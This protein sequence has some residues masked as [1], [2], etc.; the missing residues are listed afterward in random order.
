[1]LAAERFRRLLSDLTLTPDDRADGLRAQR[2]VRASLQAHYYGGPSI[3]DHSRLI[4]AWSKKTEVSPPRG[5][6]LLFVLPPALRDR[7]WLD[8]PATNAPLQIM[9][10]VKQVIERQYGPA[11][12]R[13]DGRAIGVAVGRQ[14]VE[15]RPA[16]AAA[17]SQYLACDASE[18]GRFRTSDPGL[19]EAHVRQA[20][21]RTRGNARDLIRMLK[22]WQGFRAVPLGSFALELL[23]IEFLAAWPQAGEAASF[24]DW[25]VRDCFEYLV[26]QV[27]RDLP[28][29]GSDERI[30][31]G[32]AWRLGAREA[33]AHAA[34]ACD[35]EMTDLNADAWW[36]WEKIFGERVP[37][38]TRSSGEMGE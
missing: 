17:G 19:E 38:D 23:A 25:M 37:L 35:F 10:D 27:S 18:G 11:R 2:A 15:V 36:E 30:A 21:H 14:M 26:N 3:Q 28:V 9:L 31:L 34:R 5:I 24:Y 22:C 20:D 1:M 16:F 29:P 13:P 7:A 8:P 32:E 4:G 33:H 6:D 12:I